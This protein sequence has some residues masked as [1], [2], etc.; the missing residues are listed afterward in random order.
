M[1]ADFP[2]SQNP[3]LSKHL[4]MSLLHSVT[5]T[6][7]FRS[8]F[9][10]PL[11][12]KTFWGDPNLLPPYPENFDN[13]RVRLLESISAPPFFAADLGLQSFQLCKLGR[14]GKTDISFFP[15]LPPFSAAVLPF[16]AIS[17]HP[18]LLPLFPEPG[19]TDSFQRLNLEHPRTRD[20]VSSPTMVA[21][22]VFLSAWPRPPPFFITFLP[23]KAQR[24]NFHLAITFSFV[25][26]QMSIHF[27]ALQPLPPPCSVGALSIFRNL[28]EDELGERLSIRFSREKLP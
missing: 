16:F 1:L 5:Q 20:S 12:N 10:W 17:Q 14:A 15:L 13:H 25:S 24:T 7:V 23:C 2:S 3:T 21:V 6:L 22:R 18:P 4:S 28:F 19:R 26:P 9:I 11:P 8:T 27:F